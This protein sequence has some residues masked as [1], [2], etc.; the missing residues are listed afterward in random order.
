MPYLNIGRHSPLE[1]SLS[2]EESVLEVFRRPLLHWRV[3]SVGVDVD[4][5]AGEKKDSALEIHE[6]ELE[7]TC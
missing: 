2:W 6:D 3:V 7:D 5:E 4:C 1:G